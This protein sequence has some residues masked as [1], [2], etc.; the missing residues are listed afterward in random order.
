MMGLS[1]SE[2]A[3]VLIILASESSEGTA[4]CVK[5]GGKINYRAKYNDWDEIER[6]GEIVENDETAIV[7]TFDVS[8]EHAMRFNLHFKYYDIL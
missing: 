3:F 1:E 7:R 6:R 5:M 2:N 4:D 8:R